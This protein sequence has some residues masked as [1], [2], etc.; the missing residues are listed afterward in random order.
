MRI[1][2]PEQM[3]PVL[4]PWPREKKVRSDEKDHYGE[5]SLG[6][7]RQLS[8]GDLSLYIANRKMFESIYGPTVADEKELLFIIQMADAIADK[9]LPRLRTALERF[10]GP[11]AA[12]KELNHPAGFHGMQ[13]LS[14][15]FNVRTHGAAPI[16]YWSYSAQRLAFGLHCPDVSTALFLL[17]LGKVGVGSIGRCKACAM[18]FIGDRASKRF[19]DDNCRSRYF[20]RQLRARGKVRKKSKSKK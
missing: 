14:F 18:A 19:C 11:V 1:A 3:L 12:E 16:V 17:A 5:H 6:R 10:I 7:V 4:I 13:K 15:R 9:S 20:M 8:P 2:L